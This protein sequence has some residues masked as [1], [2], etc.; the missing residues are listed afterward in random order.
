MMYCEGNMKLETS[1]GQ[2]LPQM[3]S[4][5]IDGHFL[6]LSGGNGKTMKFVAADWD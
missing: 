1:F 5:K 3:T 2:E 4:Y 6:T